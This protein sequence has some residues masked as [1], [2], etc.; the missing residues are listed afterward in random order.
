MVGCGF[1]KQA[2]KSLRTF[3]IRFSLT[4]TTNVGLNRGLSPA[5]LLKF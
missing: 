4:F 2:E 5:K 1:S 3:R